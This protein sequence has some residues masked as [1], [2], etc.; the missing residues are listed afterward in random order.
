MVA[1]RAKKKRIQAQAN[2]RDGRPKVS[3]KVSADVLAVSSML[4]I[5]ALVEVLQR[6]GIVTEQEVHDVVRSQLQDN[7][8]SFSQG[9]IVI[10][11]PALTRDEHELLDRIAQT[12]RSSSLNTH[13]AK[14]V[15]V[16]ALHLIEAS[17][18]EAAKAG[19]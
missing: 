12:L 17:E 11:P 18:W 14:K 5:A 15:L 2:A 9:E 16:G 19:R 10:E 6:K 4:E 1:D 13:Q 7:L 8:P 3:A